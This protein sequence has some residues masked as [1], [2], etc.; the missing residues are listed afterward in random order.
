[1]TPILLPRDELRR[2]A[3]QQRLDHGDSRLVRAESLE[4]ERML[5]EHML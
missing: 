1:M 5:L 3:E 4:Q 2:T